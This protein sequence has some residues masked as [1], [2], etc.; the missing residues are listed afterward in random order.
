[1]L[2]NVWDCRWSRPA[3][4]LTGVADALQPEGEWVCVRE[5]GRRTVRQEDCTDC[6]HWEATAAVATAGAMSVAPTA[7]LSETAFV[8]APMTAAEVQATALRAL[9]VLIGLGFL[10]VGF[11]ILDSLV[12]IPFTIGLWLCAAVFFGIASFARMPTDEAEAEEN[13]AGAAK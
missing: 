12:A 11:T 8:T 4:R 5:G 10:A 6:T 1:M 13:F 3:H 9:L 7:L 2:H